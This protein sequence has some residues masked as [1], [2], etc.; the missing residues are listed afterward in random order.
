M[1]QVQTKVITAHVPAVLADR[2]DVLA[3]KLER[4]R[5]WVVKQALSAWLEKTELRERLTREAM[6]DVDAGNVFDDQEVQAWV[7]SLDSDN[8]LL[9]PNANL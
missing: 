5:G 7:A 3:E 2:I 6:A 8:P 4:S 1:A 9:P